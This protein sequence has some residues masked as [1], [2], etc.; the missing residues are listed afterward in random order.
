MRQNSCEISYPIQIN[1][2]ITASYYVIYFLRNPT[3]C[4]CVCAFVELDDVSRKTLKKGA[5]STRTIENAQFGAPA[6]L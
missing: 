3:V 1:M 6:G 2:A 5:K 4:V